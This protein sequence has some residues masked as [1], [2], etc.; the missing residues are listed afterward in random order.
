MRATSMHPHPWAWPCSP[1]CPSTRSTST[2][3]FPTG[4]LKPS[5]PTT[6]APPSPWQDTPI[7][8][9]TPQ[10]RHSHR[11]CRRWCWSCYAATQMSWWCRIRLSLICNRSR[12]D[13]AGWTSPAPSASCVAWQTRPS[14]LLWSGLGAASS[15][16]SSGW[17]QN[18]SFCPHALTSL[19]VLSP[20][21]VDLKSFSPALITSYLTLF[22]LFLL[23]ST[24]LLLLLLLLLLY[25]VFYILND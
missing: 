5:V 9:C 17:V 13:G 24:T 8:T 3:P 20:N 7:Q 11:V 14:S 16:R 4:Q 22:I 19:H 15:S 2:R 12:V 23:Q 25:N 1:M 10:P 18:S 21:R 6:P